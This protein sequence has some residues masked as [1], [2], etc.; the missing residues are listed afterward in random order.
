MKFDRNNQERTSK[1][2][3]GRFDLGDFTLQSGIVLKNAFISYETHGTLNANKDNV[4]LYPTWFTGVHSDN[5][6]A[7]GPEKALDPTK[8][9]IIVPD[10]FG[11]GLSSSPTNSSA[12]QN[13]GRFPLTTAYD[14]IN[15]QR[16]L[17]E[18]LFGVNEILSVVGFS[19]AAQ[20]AFHWAALYPEMIR[21]IVPICGSAK[22]SPHNWLHL[23][24][25]KKA[26][27]ADPSWKGGDYLTP[28]KE[29]LR[30]FHTVS[31]GWFL[32]QTYFREEHYK[33]FFGSSSENITD[34]LEN[35]YS[36]FSHLDA[37]NLLAMLN[38]WQNADVSNHLKFRGELEKALGSIVCPAM[39][40]PC[41]NDLYFPP[42]DSQAAVS[43]MKDAELRII[44]SDAGHLA[45]FPGFDTNCDRLIDEG[46]ADL[47]SRI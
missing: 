25:M 5:R 20:Q 39:V 31:A 9:F 18:Q 22:T 40:M 33:T 26:L 4:I 10:M 6:A 17:C 21:S 30:A 43:M 23:E 13:R 36:M 42:E 15:A 12:H 29:G 38:T 44:S 2:V 19:M 41:D 46:I 35:G 32:S 11:N 28:P 14:N 8:F 47:L 16:L 45:G 27:Q 7:I 37:N 3:E 24:G 1:S 34:F